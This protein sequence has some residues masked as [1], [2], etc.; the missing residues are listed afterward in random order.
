MERIETAPLTG[1]RN[2]AV[3]RMSGR[4]LP[5]VLVQG[6]L[7]PPQRRGRWWRH[8]REATCRRKSGTLAPVRT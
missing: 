1:S 5:G 2:D 7:H 4:W 6:A 8:A 3:V